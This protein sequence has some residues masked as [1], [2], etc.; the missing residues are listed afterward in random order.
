MD[1]MGMLL[2]CEGVSRCYIRHRTM[3]L[4]Y[5]TL[6]AQE[7]KDFVMFTIKQF[8]HKVIRSSGFLVQRSNAL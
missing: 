8:K 4:I 1:K 6:E 2:D 3:E 5:R 7:M